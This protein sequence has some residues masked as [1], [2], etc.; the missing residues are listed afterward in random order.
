M[1]KKKGKKGKV[2]RLALAMVYSSDC[3]QSPKKVK[4]ADVPYEPPKPVPK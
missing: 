2:K 1:G 3:V 4:K